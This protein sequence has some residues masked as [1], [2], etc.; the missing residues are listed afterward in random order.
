[1]APLAVTTGMERVYD[2]LKSSVRRLQAQAGEPTNGSESAVLLAGLPGGGRE[3]GPFERVE[4]GSRLSVA[5]VHGERATMLM[6]APAKYARSTLPFD[7]R[8]TEGAAS[9]AVADL[10]KFRP[11]ERVQLEAMREERRRFARDIHDGI[12]Q[13]LTGA[14]MQLEAASRLIDSDPATARA[15]VTAVCELIASEQRELRNLIRKTEPAADRSLVGL[16]ELASVLE[17]IRDRFGQQWTLS[18]ELTIGGHGHVGRSLSDDIYSIIQEALANVGRHAR[19]KVCR[20]SLVLLR[21]KVCI[22]VVDD[23]CG[24]PFH[25]RYDL[26]ALIAREI[27]PVSLRERIAARHGA[28]TLVSSL[29]GAKLEISLPLKA[30]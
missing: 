20:V 25:G 29:S 19:A 15:C 9:Q 13:A 7:D 26:P 1:M 12:L 22:T 16:S 8:L 14:A 6:T 23:G 10:T 28:L 2:K 4:S 3:P 5:R 24:F 30:S 21:N 11:K 17:S 18:I 27:G